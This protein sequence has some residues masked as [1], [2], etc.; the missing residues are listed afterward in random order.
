MVSHR[1]LTAGA[2]IVIAAVALTKCTPPN[3][4]ESQQGSHSDDLATCAD[5]ASVS[6]ET[7]A[8][9]LEVPWGLSFAPDGRLF[10]TERPGRIRVIEEGRLSPDPWATVDVQSTGEAGLM[11]IAIAPDFATSGAVYVVGTFASAAGLVNRVVRLTE[12]EGRGVGAEVVVD[13][14]PS[15]RFHAGAAIAFGPDGLLY[16]TAGDAREPRSAQRPADLAGK[17]LRYRPDGAIPRDN[18]VP[19]SPVFAFG[20]RNAQGLAWHPDGGDLVATEHG[21]SGFPDERLRT[22]NDE[23]NVIVAGANY[24]WPTVAGARSDTGFVAPIVAWNPGIAPSGVAVYTGSRF[25]WSGSIVVAALKAQELRLVEIVRDAASPIAWRAR[26]E[27]ALFRGELGRL[28]AVAM[29]TDGHLYL[30]TSNRDGRGNPSPEDDRILRVV[31]ASARAAEAPS[32][33]P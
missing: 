30:S 2:L 23:L 32:L 13:G 10:V 16:V 3:D 21:P 1:Y 5:T 33:T 24:G 8:G 12:R 19:G 17:V 4:E 11:G 6:V 9:G 31:P 7:V 25:P 18:P 27:R 26:C 22:D 15:G 14:I 20:V 29:G 28:R